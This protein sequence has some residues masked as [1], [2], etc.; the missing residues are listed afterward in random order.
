[1]HLVDLAGSERLNKTEAVGDRLKEAQHINKSLS[2]LGDVIASLPQKNA[3]VPCRNSKLTQLLQDSLGGQAKTLMFVHINPEPESIRETLSTLKFAER[4]SSVEL[5]AAKS[6]INLSRLLKA[7]LARKDGETRRSPYSSSPERFRMKSSVSSSPSQASIQSCDASSDHSFPFFGQVKSNSTDKLERGSLDFQDLSTWPPIGSPWTPR[8]DDKDL[9]PDDW[10]DKVMV[11]S[12]NIR[13][14]FQKYHTKSPNKG[15][16]YI[17]DGFEV[18]T[19]NSSE[20]NFN[21]PT[22][23]H[24]SSNILNRSKAKKTPAKQSKSQDTSSSIPT[25]P[26]GSRVANVT[27]TR[28]LKSTSFD[29][30][31]KISNSK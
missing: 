31:R 19:S 18:S 16:D 7:A 3:H 17:T 6:N 28:S 27:N 22:D 2:A 9:V 12:P 23:L 1:M 24:R 4:V 26:A 10:V 25:I 15:L 20:A 13:L 29:S 21:V 8:G 11:N 30:R 5:G 14:N